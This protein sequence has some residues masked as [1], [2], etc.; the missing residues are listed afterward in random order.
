M[1]Q[2]STIKIP[3]VYSKYVLAIANYLTKTQT[4]PPIIITL[5]H[6]RVKTLFL[7][8]GAREITFLSSQVFCQLNENMRS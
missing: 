1:F 8:Q 7:K 3:E 4:I 2:E 6:N 5:Y